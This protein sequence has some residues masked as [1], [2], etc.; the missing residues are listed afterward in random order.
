MSTLYQVR[1]ILGCSISNRRPILLAIL[2]PSSKGPDHYYAGPGGPYTL[3]MPCL[4]AGGDR[5]FIPGSIRTGTTT[6]HF[7][8]PGP[9]IG[10]TG[11]CSSHGSSR[12]STESAGSTGSET[13]GRCLAPSSRLRTALA[14]C[15]LIYAGG[16][17][18]FW[19]DAQLTMH[20]KVFASH[21]DF[22]RHVVRGPCW[23]HMPDIEIP[24]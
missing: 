24:V 8:S 13:H 23:S 4:H 18:Y 10:R 2:P 14:S 9:Q 21:K 20:R 12:L 7:Q 1:R 17:H 6:Q 15:F 11:Q 16:R 3:V 22:M 19:A 5:L